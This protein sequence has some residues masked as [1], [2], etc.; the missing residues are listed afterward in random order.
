MAEKLI[1]PTSNPPPPDPCL[2]IDIM[3]N[4][5][6]FSSIWMG[7]GVSFV[8]FGSVARGRQG[9]TPYFYNCFLMLWLIM[10]FDFRF[11]SCEMSHG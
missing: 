5:N 9:A 6:L 11:P 3:D 4:G 2:N 1:N 7:K 10:I 8:V